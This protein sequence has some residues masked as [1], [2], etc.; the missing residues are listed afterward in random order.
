MSDYL[1]EI[2]IDR[3]GA[4]RNRTVGPFSPG[5]NVVYGPNE[6]G[7]SSIAAFV[8]GVLFGWDEAY[9]VRNTYRVEGGER[10]GSLVFAQPPS[11]D[12]AENRRRIEVSRTR[13]ADGLVGDENLFDDIDS[14][15]FKTMFALNSDE[16]RSLNNSSD[17]TARLLTAGTGTGSS[18][19]GAFVE[20]EQRI[21]A[22]TSPA[23]GAEGSVVRMA[24]QLDA[25]RERMRE[26]AAQEDLHRQQDRELRDLKASRAGLAQSVAN[27]NE[28]VDRLSA[29]Q[30]RVE[31]LDSQIAQL[32]A[33]IELVESDRANADEHTEQAS[34]SIDDR[35]LALDAASERKLRDALDE[36]ADEQ[37]KIARSVDIAQENSA[38]SSAAYEALVE[39]DAK[40][41]QTGKVTNPRRVQVGLSTLLTIIFIAAGIPVF[42]H[43][44]II[45]SLSLTALGA[46]LVVVALV[47][48]AA[49]LAMLLRP[50]KSEDTGES[51]RQDAQWVMLQDQKKLDAILASRKN[52]DS[53][54][55]AFMEDA[56]L[57]E[58]DGSIKYARGLLDDAREAR[59]QAGA[60]AQRKAALDMRLAAA[61]DSLAAC[62]SQRSAAIASIGTPL[63]E[64]PAPS[65]SP[66]ESGS[67]G[68]P[69][70]LSAADTLAFSMANGIPNIDDAPSIRERLRIETE[71]RNAL[72]SALDDMNV[73]IGELTVALEHAAKDRSF[74]IAKYEFE[75]LRSRLR[76]GKR[77]LASLLLAKR[78]LEKSIAAWESR[79]QPEVF[80]EASRL[81]AQ[82]TNG[83]WTHVAMTSEGGLVAEAPNGSS[84]E[85]RHLSMGTTQQL[86]LALRIAMLLQASDV[87]R[88]VPVLADDVLVHFDE[89][90]RKAAAAAL[91]ELAASR[92]VIVFTGHR[93]TVR[94]LGAACA[95]LTCIELR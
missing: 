77:E 3:F 87:G 7:K 9:G 13:N 71:Q 84:R 79:N 57:G 66:S 15:T 68:Y 91:A 39:L 73:R 58:A 52:L 5:L 2:R 25:V 12:T 30:A 36:Y 75:R 29:A 72:S 90:R 59:A 63:A 62:K 95:N 81:F 46:G 10:S 38:T 41:G 69:S 48:A 32:T 94:A 83:A 19:A 76:D 82:M 23:P 86:Y 47:M 40:S 80:S 37:E 88:A 64:T 45:N 8:G 1:E 53:E 49:A 44:R 16:L 33:E 70:A 43:G 6:A 61:R 78:M 65:L 27:L 89:N 22:L 21:A 92:Q 18:P 31:V 4:L 85:V 14:A 67:I 51:R 50:A 74:D 26:Q 34:G 24:E 28:S 35:L 11:P 55:R 42:V 17:V 93:E 60:S 54:I 20:L 56:G